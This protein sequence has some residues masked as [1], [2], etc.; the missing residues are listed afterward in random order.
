MINNIGEYLMDQNTL[1]RLQN[2]ELEILTAFDR[3]CTENDIRYSLYAGTALGAVRHKGFISWDD[4]I[5]IVMTRGEYNIFIDQIR[6]HPIDGYT[7]DSPELNPCCAISHAKLMKDD[8]LLISSDW[9][10][11]GEGNHGIWI[12][13][14]PLDKIT[15]KTKKRIYKIGKKI[16]FLTRAHGGNKNDG[17]VKTAIRTLARCIP[18]TVASRKL[19]RY[20][21]ELAINDLKTQTNYQWTVLAAI[22]T[23]QY[24]YKAEMMEKMHRTAFDGHMFLITDSYESMLHQLYGDYMTLP[25]PEEQV[26]KHQPARIAF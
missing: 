10:C 15:E 17:W 7:L 24:V 21:Y 25:P 19:D 22:C 18:K 3:F 23:F 8:T 14:F 13:I 6:T 12:D 5:D 4:D 11:G 20:L 16:V 26:C 1:K 9:K 2:T